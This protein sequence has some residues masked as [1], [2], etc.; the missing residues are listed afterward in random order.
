[1]TTKLR[2]CLCVATLTGLSLI[3]SLV[4]SNHAKALTWSVNP[5]TQ[6]DDNVPVLGGFTIDDEL[7]AN[8][9]MLSSNVA[10]SSIVFGPNDALIS[11]TPGS[12]IT[13]ID[14]L[15]SSSNLLS[16]VFSLPLTTSG[17][18]IALDSVVSTFTPFD[19]GTPFA[20][21]GSVSATTAEVPGPTALMGAFAAVAWSRKMRGRIAHQSDVSPRRRRQQ[22]R[23]LPSSGVTWQDQP[24][25]SRG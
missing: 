19:V 21:T 2:H 1:M 13:A 8:P 16:F 18:D 15:D 24:R 17:G 9:I 23:G 20:I 5:G 4:S 25:R 14:W 12:G 7:A 11:S 10:I 22:L 3:G 6:T